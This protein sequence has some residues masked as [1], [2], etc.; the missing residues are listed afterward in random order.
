[1]YFN[2]T[3]KNKEKQNKGSFLL[4]LLVAFAIISISM[5]VVVDAFITSQTSYR[6]T[7]ERSEL[8]QAIT[9]LFEDMTREA[10]VSDSYTHTGSELS[11]MRIEGLNGQP[12]ELVSYSLSPEGEIMKKVGSGDSLPITPNTIEVTDAYI[13]T[14]NPDDE[15]ARAIIS[16]SAMIKDRPNTEVHFQTSV[17]ERLR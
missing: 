9:Y 3:K 10:R 13:R 14:P 1:M 2:S 16:I 6:D 4:E 5:V 8:A 17:T 15:S 7:A 12:E 11:M